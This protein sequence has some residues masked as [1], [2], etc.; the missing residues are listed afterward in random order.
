M[1]DLINFCNTFVIFFVK[2]FYVNYRNL[3]FH[4]VS[5]YANLTNHGARLNRSFTQLQAENLT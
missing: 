5:F 1:T 2:H 3:T 4:G